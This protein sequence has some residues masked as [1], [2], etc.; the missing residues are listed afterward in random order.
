MSE[1]DAFPSRFAVLK[2]LPERYH[3]TRRLAIESRKTFIRLNVASLLPLLG[4]GLVFYLFSTLLDTLQVRAPLSIPANASGSLGFAAIMIFTTLL[5]LSLH[6]LCHGLAFQFFG[7]KPKYGI[8]LKKAVAYASAT[9]YYLA[10]DAYI[11]V[12]LA[13]LVI[14]SCLAVV[15]MALSDGVL[16]FWIGL[17]GALNAGASVGDLWFVLECLRLPPT[18]LARDFGDGTELYTPAPSATA[19]TRQP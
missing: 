6:E 3:L 8:S 2:Q 11:V 18:T 1:S 9:D 4:T 5:L 12:G 10:R 14:L 13:P 7:A 15:G 19:T 17:L 16:R